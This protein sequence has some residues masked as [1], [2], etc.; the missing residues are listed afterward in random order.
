[1]EKSAILIKKR[2]EISNSNSALH[3]HRNTEL[4]KYSFIEHNLRDK[5]PKHEQK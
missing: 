5:K 2:I 1:M 4:R 3:I